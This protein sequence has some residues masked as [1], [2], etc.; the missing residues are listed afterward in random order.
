MVLLLV[1]LKKR[2]DPVTGTDEILAELEEA[3]NHPRI[4]LLNV[5]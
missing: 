2:A 4:Q 5:Y 3:T 1:L